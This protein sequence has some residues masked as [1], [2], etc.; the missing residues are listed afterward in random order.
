[1][2]VTGVKTG[3]EHARRIVLG[4]YVVGVLASCIS[5]ALRVQAQVGAVVRPA[6]ALGPLVNIPQTLNNCGPATVAEVLAYWG[7][8]RTQDEVQAVLRVDGIEHGMVP[9]GVPVYARGVGLQALAGTGGTEVLVK[10][11]IEA[12]FP[13]IVSQQV[14]VVDHVGHW[15]PIEAY[16]DTQSVFTASDPYLGQGHTLTYA[17]FDTI[18]ARGGHGFM[19]LYPASRAGALRAALARGGWNKKAAYQHDVTRLLARLRSSVPY[20]AI[21]GSYSPTRILGFRYLGLAWDEAQ[22]GRAADAR[23]YL[24]QATRSGANP[25]EVGWIS[26][27]IG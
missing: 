3:R 18:W 9:Y 25:I 5:P 2:A 16:D 24:D 23:R 6:T 12:G 7:V 15:R 21:V 19:V 17:D 20:G 14:S 4:L 11:L 1:M 8:N 26:A 27:A 10:V 22:L 13:V